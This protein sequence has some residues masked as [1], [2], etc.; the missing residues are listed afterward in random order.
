M[1]LL[2]QMGF[3][4]ALFLNDLGYRANGIRIDSGDLAYLSQVAREIFQKLAKK[5][6]LPWFVNLTIVASNDI[7]EDTIKSLNAQNHRI[8][9]FG[10]GTHLVTCQKQPALGC[11]YKLAEIIITNLES[12]WVKKLEKLHCLVG[13]LHIDFMEWMVLL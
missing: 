9:C 12:S 6:D 2:F 8:D 11:V 10:V 1:L 4:V 13:K 7:N 3:P 5:F